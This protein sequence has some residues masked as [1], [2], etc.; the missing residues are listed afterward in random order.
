MLVLLV[1]LDLGLKVLVGY[2]IAALL[3]TPFWFLTNIGF[4]PV[5]W[6]G[7]AISIV[8]LG[9]WDCCDMFHLNA[10]AEWAHR[11]ISRSA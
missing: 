9:L 7:L 2:S 4:Q 6:I 5:I 10:M 3:W 1:P 8:L 11:L